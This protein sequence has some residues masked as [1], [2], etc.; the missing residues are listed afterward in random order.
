VGQNQPSG[1]VNRILQRETIQY[2]I[3]V[4]RW[5]LIILLVFE[6]VI[7]IFV[8]KAPQ[9]EYKPGLGI[10]PVENSYSLQG[11]E[12]YGVLHYFADGEVQT[13]Y[14]DGI[15]IVVL[16]DSTVYAA[17][18][19][20]DDNFV[21]LTEVAL[22]ERGLAVDMHNL[23]RSDRTVADHVFIAPAV[24][25]VYAPKYV[26]F[27]LSRSSFTESFDIKKENYFID[28]GDGNLE[29]VHQDL[30]S[31]SELAFSNL[32]SHSGLL[33]FWN[34]RVGITSAELS[35]KYADGFWKQP[36]AGQGDM[37]IAQPSPSD[38]AVSETENKLFKQQALPQIRA[39]MDAY[40]NSAIIFLIIPYSPSI[41]LQTMGKVSW[42][43]PG[44]RYLATLLE[45]I[46]GVHV[47]Y[48][49]QVF[50]DSYNAFN[51]LPRGEFNSAFNF[52]H[53]NKDGH[54]AVAHALTEALV[55]ILK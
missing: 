32:I 31:S 45:K 11:T 43:S 3:Q 51:V 38:A 27:Q 25:A 17:Q 2:W 50:E 13:P 24:N 20:P 29:L 40:P 48:T 34:Y 41:S 37:N 30:T 23:G 10:V 7:R 47:V 14:R 9:R 36:N 15:S 1:R 6:I 52:G 21:S 16:G 35:T 4:A 33:T 44:D 39:L 28:E 42:A 12:G 26:I 8:V 19:N 22:R 53:L 5:S 18:V 54:A 49:Q 46:D 55:E